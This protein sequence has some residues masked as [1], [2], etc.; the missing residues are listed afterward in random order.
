[1]E[2]RA[3]VGII[4]EGGWSTAATFHDGE[5]DLAAAP[6]MKGGRGYAFGEVDPDAIVEEIVKQLAKMT[7][8]ALTPAKDLREAMQSQRP[9]SEVS[10]SL[11]NLALEVTR[12]VND[13]RLLSSGPTTGLAE[14]VLPPVAPGSSIMPGKVNPSIL[15]MVNMV[16]YQVIGSDTTVALAV[17][18]GQL[19]LNA[20][21]ARGSSL[22]KNRPV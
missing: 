9:M 22:R 4:V 7:G 21:K 18:A 1:M 17:Q 5:L 20:C 13:L 19:E 8:F 16:A 11:R 10:G 15:E 2:E 6:G 14:I 3:K 12:I